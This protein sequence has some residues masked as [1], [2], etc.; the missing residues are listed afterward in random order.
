MHAY[1]SLQFA[2]VAAVL[3]EVVLDLHLKKATIPVSFARVIL[4]LTMQYYTHEGPCMHDA[5]YSTTI[6]HFWVVK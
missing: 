4:I 6:M 5:L 1:F 2:M 3:V